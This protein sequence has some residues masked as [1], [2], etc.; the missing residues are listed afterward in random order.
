[1]P[2]IDKNKCINCGICVKECPVGA[3]FI[4]D[5]KAVIDME[6]C[7]RC[8]RCHDICPKEA[9]RH[10]SE[11]IPFEI[12]EKI[13]EIERN[14]DNFRT[15]KEKDGFLERMIRYYNKEKRVSEGTIEEINKRLK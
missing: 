1:M 13:E 9:V 5:K 8:G 10:D 3:I 12:K 15:K 7:I 6:K 4:K 2:W 14:L 11:R